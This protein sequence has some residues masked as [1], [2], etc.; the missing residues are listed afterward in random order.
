MMSEEKQILTRIVEH[1]ALTGEVADPQ[2]TVVHLPD[3]KTSFV[4]PTA[5]GGRGIG[6]DEFRFDGRV[7]WAAYSSRTKTVYISDARKS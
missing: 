3:N 7:V 6:L 2:V 4:E 5:D 1:Y